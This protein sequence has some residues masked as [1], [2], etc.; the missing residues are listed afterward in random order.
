MGKVLVPFVFAFS[1]SLLLIV[2]GFSWSEFF[3]AAS[4]AML[5]I[6]AL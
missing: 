1:P 6:W 2:E 5:G 4:G 3:A